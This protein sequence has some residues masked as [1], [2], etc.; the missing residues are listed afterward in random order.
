[1]G[2]SSFSLPVHK[3]GSVPVL[4][5]WWDHGL[6][7]DL[8]SQSDKVSKLEK[9]SEKRVKMPGLGM[10]RPYRSE[11]LSCLYGNKI[12]SD[13]TRLGCLSMALAHTQRACHK[14]TEP[15]MSVLVLHL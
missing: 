3:W 9:R 15:V 5:Q 1:M 8:V 12:S 14:L 10:N 4:F 11:V 2:L 7:S 6:I 13:S